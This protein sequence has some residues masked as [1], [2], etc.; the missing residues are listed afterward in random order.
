M[1]SLPTSLYKYFEPKRVD[2]LENLKIRFTPRSSFNDPFDLCPAIERPNELEYKIFEK[3][4]ADSIYWKLVLSGHKIS[5]K[6]FNKLHQGPQQKAR[7]LLIKK[8]PDFFGEELARR[9]TDW[10]SKA[11][12]I[13]CLS[14]TSNNL[15][16][17]SHYTDSHKGFVIEFDPNHS[18]FNKPNK[19]P[20]LDFG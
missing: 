11:I 2:V 12:G 20:V 6:Q 5:R 19:P 17:W 13:L 9:Q 1:S 18:F 14:E 15:L 10:F 7:E 8:H 3:R 4:A 16:M